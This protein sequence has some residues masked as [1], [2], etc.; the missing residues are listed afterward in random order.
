LNFLPKWCPIDTISISLQLILDLHLKALD[1]IYDFQSIGMLHFV[2]PWTLVL[3]GPK[4]K[5][6][7]VRDDTTKEMFKKL[8]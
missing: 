7:I 4:F 2:G 1:P 5:E 6:N 3:N 8:V